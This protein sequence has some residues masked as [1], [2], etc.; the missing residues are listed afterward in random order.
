MKEVYLI[1]CEYAFAVVNPYQNQERVA[2][3]HRENILYA[4]G[5]LKEART[6][7][8]TKFVNEKVTLELEAKYQSNEYLSKDPKQ[9]K[10]KK[11]TELKQK[12]LD[13]KTV[14]K[15]LKYFEYKRLVSKSKYYVYSLTTDGKSEKIFGEHYGKVLFD[16]LAKLPLDITPDDNISECIK[17][18]G[19]FVAHIFVSNATQSPLGNKE[20]WIIEA[21][22]PRM[23]FEWFIHN[24]RG[25]YAIETQFEGY[26]RTLQEAEENYRSIIFP[27]V[28]KEQLDV[29]KRQRDDLK[30]KLGL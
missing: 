18:L 8:I 15:W 1:M 16:S 28:Y 20:E 12:Q 19:S 5:I 24:F 29:L 4:L 27:N 21:I 30:K 14:Q 11:Q 2:K 17:R 22:N 26:M 7:E 3:D 6:A 9:T 13:R 23:M 25:E 10:L